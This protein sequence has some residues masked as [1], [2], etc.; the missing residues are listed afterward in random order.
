MSLAVDQNS[1]SKGGDPRVGIQGC[2]PGGLHRGGGRV[3]Q[4]TQL[5]L[6]HSPSGH[7]GFPAGPQVRRA[8]PVGEK[9]PKVLSELAPRH[10]LAGYGGVRG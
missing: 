8:L 1:F 9:E 6:M 2:C 10:L 3:P 7:T 5:S 4:E